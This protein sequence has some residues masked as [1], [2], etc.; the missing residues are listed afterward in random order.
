[1]NRIERILAGCEKYKYNFDKWK[2]DVS[3]FAS[4]DFSKKLH[5]TDQLECNEAREEIAIWSTSSNL[6]GLFCQ[7]WGNDKKNRQEALECLESAK[8]KTTEEYLMRGLISLIDIAK[9]EMN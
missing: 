2:S 7:T 8:E 1:M 3:K 4:D 9:E 5:S 6:T